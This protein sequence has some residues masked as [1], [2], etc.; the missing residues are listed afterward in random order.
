MQHWQLPEPHLLGDSPPPHWGP[1]PNPDF[2]VL[3][4]A[5]PV[6]SLGGFLRLLG[7]HS[8]Q[9]FLIACFV[10]PHFYPCSCHFSWPAFSVTQNNITILLWNCSVVFFFLLHKVSINLG[11]I[12]NNEKFGKPQ[13]TPPSLSPV[14]KAWPLGP[15]DKPAGGDHTPCLLFATHCGGC[16]PCPG[17]K[18]CCPLFYRWRLKLTKRFFLT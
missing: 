17:V 5:G 15:G 9:V 12:I 1:P 10:D 4:G 11:R 2:S 7:F 16:P 3:L 18:W 14:G 8:S 6:G 13:T